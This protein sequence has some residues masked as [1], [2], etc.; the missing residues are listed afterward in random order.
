MDYIVMLSNVIDKL[1]E[2][3]L[4]L[5]ICVLTLFEIY[6]IMGKE[7]ITKSIGWN[8]DRNI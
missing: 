5:L 7:I 8:C 6:D 1:T 3:N 2:S 4:R